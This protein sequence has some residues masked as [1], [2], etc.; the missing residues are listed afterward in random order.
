MGK[1]S[2]SVK[3]RYR[4]KTY[5]RV[6]LVLPKGHK[7]EIKAAADAVNESV[8]SFITTAV[9]QRMEREAMTGAPK[10]GAG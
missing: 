2:S 6:E 9:D 7:A 5:D 3:N 1:T 10:T 4:D 8:N